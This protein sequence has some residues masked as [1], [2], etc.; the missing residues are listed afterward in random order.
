MGAI[1]VKCRWW[2]VAGRTESY[3]DG[4]CYSLVCSSLRCVSANVGVDWVLKHGVWGMNLG[5]GL[6]QAAWRQPEGMGVRSSTDRNTL[7]LNA[8]RGSTDCH[9]SK[10]PF[11]E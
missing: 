3:T 4:P 7:P 2:S 11:V 10:V 9:G 8:L 6:L 5:K 1:R